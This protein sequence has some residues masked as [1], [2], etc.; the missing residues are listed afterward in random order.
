MDDTDNK[1]II[2]NFRAARERAKANGEDGSCDEKALI[3]PHTSQEFDCLLEC[4]FW[5]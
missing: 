3:I 5:E 1:D 4:I 2:S